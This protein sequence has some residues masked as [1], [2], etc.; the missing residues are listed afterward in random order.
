MTINDNDIVNAIKDNPEYGF[1]LL[2]MK[3]KKRIYWH[4]RRIVVRHE[5]AQDVAQEAF[6]RI[7]RSCGSCHESKTFSAWVYRIATNEALRCLSKRRN[8]TLEIDDNDKCPLE[9]LADEFVDYGNAEAVKLQNAI[10]RLPAKQQLVFNMRY[11]DELDYN[12]IAQITDS[13]Y[14]GVKMNYHLAKEK[15]TEYLKLND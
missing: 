8:E 5:D 2:M 12:E 3:Y 7:F 1:R 13:T 15:I 11:Y 4:I 10:L 14:H 6:V 9:L